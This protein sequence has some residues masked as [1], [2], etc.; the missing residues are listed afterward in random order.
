M[1]WRYT[2]IARKSIVRI[3]AKLHFRLPD[4]P[5]YWLNA[6]DSSFAVISTIGMTRS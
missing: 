5:A 4:I 6:F 3:D 1:L 2:G